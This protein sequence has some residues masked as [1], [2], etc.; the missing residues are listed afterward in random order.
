MDT[1]YSKKVV[2]TGARLSARRMNLQ[3]FMEICR[4]LRRQSLERQ[5]RDL[6]FDSRGDGQPVQIGKHWRNVISSART[7]HRA[8]QCVLNAL[9]LGDVLSG[10]AM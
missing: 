10:Y 6:E 3:Q 2:I 5:Q 7:G 1:I 4:L 8:C 9:Q